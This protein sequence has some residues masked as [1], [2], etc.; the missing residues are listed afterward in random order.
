MK[1]CQK[2]QFHCP[3]SKACIEVN[4]EGVSCDVALRLMR[5]VT[6]LTI[7]ARALMRRTVG[8]IQ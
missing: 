2:E 3:V 5:C 1:D 8:T 6:L 7:V 4:K